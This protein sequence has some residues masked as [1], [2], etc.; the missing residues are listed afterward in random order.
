[1]E[2]TVAIGCVVKLDRGFPLVRLEDGAE[3]RCKHATSLVKGERVRSVIGDRVRVSFAERND[4]A[5]IVEVLPRS[6]ELVRKDPT[7]RAV[8]QVLAANFDRIIVTP[9]FQWK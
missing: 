1:M 4:K 6:R 3:L 9:A 2:E 7:E 5:L 8:P